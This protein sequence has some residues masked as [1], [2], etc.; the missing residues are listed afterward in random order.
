MKL[1]QDT[2]HTSVIFEAMFNVSNASQGSYFLTLQSCKC[3][4]IKQTTLGGCCPYWTARC[5]VEVA[6]IFVVK[7]FNKIES[8][9]YASLTGLKGKVDQYRIGITTT[10]TL[11]VSEYFE[12]IW[13]K[14]LEAIEILPSNLRKTCRT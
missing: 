12:A 1:C 6:Q 13:T 2:N 14:T 11:I 8:S 5:E 3:L 9:S 10:S 7:A 4:A